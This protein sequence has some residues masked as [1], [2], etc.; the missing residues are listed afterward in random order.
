MLQQTQVER[1]VTKYAQF[2]TAFPDFASLAR[3]D[4]HEVLKVWQ[5]MGYNRRALA[6]R[7]TALRVMR[8]FNGALPD[9]V[10]TLATLPGIGRATASAVRAF[11]FN[12]P[13]VFIET[14]IRRVFLSFFFK[15]RSNVS[16]SEIL[17]LVET[18][19]Y[20]RSPRIW[21]SALMDYGVYLKRRFPELN[22]RGAGYQKQSPFQG[23]NR[24][25]RGKVLRE[26]VKNPATET[27][28]ARVLG[29]EP[30]NIR[31]ILTQLL[32]E[33]FIVKK[34]NNFAVAG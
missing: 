16:D 17:P 14:N 5:G 8:D 4:L 30:M 33:G 6:L 7:E 13:S 26:L 32:R 18:T 28:I 29:L 25:M 15:R 2:L 34:R 23:S 1:V 31:P 19:L 3:A 22:K 27:G 10:D 12:K 21:Y 24:Q 20:K 11:A 9:D